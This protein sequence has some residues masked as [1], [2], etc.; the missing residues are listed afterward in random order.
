VSRVLVVEDEPHLLRALMLTLRNR[1]YEVTAAAT[2][3][4]ALRDVATAVPDLVILDL[5]LPDRDGVDVVRD[6]Q[7]SHPDL[8]IIVLSA[9]SGS[10]DKVLALDLGAVD[11]VTKPFDMNELLAR[12]RAALRRTMQPAVAPEVGFGDVRVD[13]D[14]RSIV[15]A[16]ESIH[17]TPNEWRILDVL[18]RNPGRLV[19]AR[20]LLTAVRGDPDHTDSSYL[21]IYIAQLRRKLEPEPNR[22]RHILTEPGLGYRFQP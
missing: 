5:G 16:D 14:A 2:A 17:L 13:L 12:V 15:R 7:G 11:Y 21:R 10:H 3:A 9:R 6:L 20:D 18:V 19:P 1:E 22:P 8:P 4:A